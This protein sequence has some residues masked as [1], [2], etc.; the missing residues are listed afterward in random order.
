MK[1]MYILL[2]VTLI[3]ITHAAVVLGQGSHKESA[4]SVVKVQSDY[5]KNGEKFVGIATGWC[6]KEPT[7]VV[8]ALHAVAGVERITVS[9]D[10]T[11]KSCD[12]KIEKVL[13]E[14]DLALLRLS[15]DLGLTPLTV[16]KVDPNSDGQFWVWGYPTGIWKKKGDRISFSLTE[17]SN[18]T[19]N[20]LLTGTNNE[21]KKKLKEQGYP[22]PDAKIIEIGSTI[23][24]GHS[25]APIFTTDGKVVGIADGG[26]REGTSSINWAMPAQTY[27]PLLYVSTQSKPTT[28][29]LQ[30]YLF[31]N[32]TKVDENATEDEQ[33]RIIEQEAEENTIV[34][35]N[36]SVTKTWTAMYNDIFWTLTDE[37]QQDLLNIINIYKIDMSDT[38][39]DVYE[40]F[41]TGATIAVPYGENFTVRDGWFYISNA[42][43]SL[44]YDALPFFSGSFENAKNNA[45]A[46]YN[47]NFPDSKWIKDPETPDEIKENNENQT[48]SYT[49]TRNSP[50]G[51]QMLYYLA[52]VDGSNLLVVFMIINRNM[53]ENRDY[54]KQVAQFYLAAQMRSF[55]DN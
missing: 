46:V 10:G 33:N 20:S 19:L 48:A 39:Y 29:S 23:V 36:Q 24:S 17:E 13:K 18:P 16:T 22:L 3:I 51:N 49:V 31:S 45:Y 38:K 52:D 34:N 41:E 32:A 11:D 53:L 25:G 47:Q 8:T 2:S 54:L 40:D 9:K 27:V 30:E 50:D 12:A 15:N 43:G 37:D 42:N 1:N 21:L 35:G 5:H 6:W 26:L 14:A 28:L 4:H 55:T 7:L 44:L